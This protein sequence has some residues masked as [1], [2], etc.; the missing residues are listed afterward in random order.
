MQLDIIRKDLEGGG[1]LYKFVPKTFH[2]EI[3][4]KIYCTGEKKKTHVN[5][6]TFLLH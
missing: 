2:E 5:Q 1:S 6:E 4:S 3:Q